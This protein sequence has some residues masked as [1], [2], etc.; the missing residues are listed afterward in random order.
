MDVEV[1]EPA[2]EAVL[3]R[4]VEVRRLLV[5]RLEERRLEPQR[6]PGLEHPVD[7]VGRGGRVGEVLEGVV[8]HHRVEDIVF[9][10]KLVRIADNGGVGEDGVLE[11][12]AARWTP[13]RS[14]GTEVEGITRQAVQPVQHLPVDLIAHVIDRHGHDIAV[15]GQRDEGSILGGEAMHRRALAHDTRAVDPNLPMTT[16]TAQQR[17]QL[18]QRHPRGVGG[19]WSG[20]VKPSRDVANP[21]SGSRG[22]TPLAEDFLQ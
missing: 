3:G 14:S 6:P 10:R 18:F 19:V 15:L 2:T 20:H 5:Q 22:Q 11:L 4:V 13:G 9:E 16:R 21:N 1:G 17:H 12:H 8:A 7:L